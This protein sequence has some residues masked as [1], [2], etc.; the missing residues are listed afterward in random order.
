MFL[1]FPFLTHQKHSSIP[2]P[3]DTC[4]SHLILLRDPPHP[5]EGAPTFSVPAARDPAV[6]TDPSCCATFFRGSE[7]RSSLS[8]V[9]WQTTK[10][11]GGCRG[12]RRA[13]KHV[14]SKGDGRFSLPSV[15]RWEGGGPRATRC[16]GIFLNRSQK[17]RFFFSFA[18]SLP[19]FKYQQNIGGFCEEPDFRGRA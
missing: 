15:V 10:R 18:Q 13:G 8:S 12:P 4:F 5:S 7:D 19:V 1:F 11:G 9:M 17:L 2:R 3:R 6:W 16:S 14:P